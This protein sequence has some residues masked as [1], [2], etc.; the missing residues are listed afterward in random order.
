MNALESAHYSP[1]RAWWLEAR[2]EVLRVW[3]TPSFALPTLLF[4]P[5]FYL[6]FGVVLASRDGARA[7]VAAYLLATYGVFGVMG[8]GLFGFGVNVAI[9]RQRGLLTLKR[10]LP[11]PPGAY[12]GAKMASAMLFAAICSVTLAVLGATVGGVDLSAGQWLALFVIDV[13]GVLPFCAI[14]LWIGSRVGGDGAPAVVNLVYL[15]MAFLSGLWMPLSILPDAVARLA[16][17]WPSY[18]LAQVALG[19]VGRD[20]GGPAWPHVAV[21]VVFTAV[22]AGLALRRLARRG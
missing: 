10:A 6:L 21:L 2:C 18:H 14:G 8:V 19:V 3:R 7:D 5:L 1:A 17:A 4:P 22:F 12:L 20:A 15:P 16:P 11:M 9:D 13:L